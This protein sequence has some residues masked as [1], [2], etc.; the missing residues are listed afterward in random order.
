[1]RLVLLPTLRAYLGR[2]GFPA[3]RQVCTSIPCALT[4]GQIRP[5]Q[6]FG[7]MG[8]QVDGRLGGQHAIPVQGMVN[9]LQ[10]GQTDVAE[11]PGRDTARAGAT[12]F[13]SVL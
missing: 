13:A 2:R 6:R 10:S 11:R 9:L 12:H 5:V 8:F 7:E 1:L 4:S 3:G